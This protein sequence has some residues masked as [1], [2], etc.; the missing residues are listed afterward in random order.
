MSRY[1]VR[2][3]YRVIENITRQHIVEM[4]VEG[5]EYLTPYVRKL[6][7][8]FTAEYPMFDETR[9]LKLCGLID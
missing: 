7:A 4:P 2:K 3:H 5:Q 1:F 9:F 6:C 8:A